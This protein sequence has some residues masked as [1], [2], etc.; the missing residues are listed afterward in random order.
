MSKK[1][2][3]EIKG[4]LKWFEREIGAEID[5]LA[6]KTAI[7]EYHEHDFNRFIEVLK[8][9]KNKISIDPSDRKTQELLERHFTKSLSILEP[10]KIRIKATDELIDE[11]VYRLYRLTKE[12][13]KIVRQMIGMIDF[14]QPN[15][16]NGVKYAW[17]I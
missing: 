10:L 2:N 1:K 5:S 12:E 3:E 7:K 17:L 9:N 14:Y 15:C 11:I 4:F 6:N 13:I 8:R 16:D